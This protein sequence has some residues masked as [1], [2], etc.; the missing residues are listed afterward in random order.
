MYEAKCFLVHEPDEPYIGDMPTPIKYLKQMASYRLLGKGI[1]EK[2][3]LKL[4]IVDMPTSI[5]EL[6]TRL[7][8]AEY[9]ALFDYQDPEW[10][11]SFKDIETEDLIVKPYTSWKTSEKNFLKQY[12]KLFEKR[13]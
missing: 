13:V 11:E 4:D 8:V 7:L 1:K 10:L 12:D 9:K 2:W 6:D 3:M 5:K